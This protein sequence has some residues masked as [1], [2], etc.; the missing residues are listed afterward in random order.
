MIGFGELNLKFPLILAISV[1]KS[2]LNFI[3]SRVEHKNS[4][5]TLGPVVLESRVAQTL[6]YLL[7]THGVGSAHT[8][9]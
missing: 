9:L 8:I 5:I 4:F 2:N 6:K 3:L 7:R 1:L